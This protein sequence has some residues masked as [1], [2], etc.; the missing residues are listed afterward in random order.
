MTATRQSLRRAARPRDPRLWA[1]L[2][3]LAVAGGWL[4]ERIG[5]PAGYLFAAM[6][7]GLCFALL[8]PGR[9]HLSDGAFKLG[10]AV[11]GVTIGTFLQGSTLGGLGWRWGPVLA[12]SAATLAVTLAAGLWLARSGPVDP[13]TASLGMV[14]GGASGIVAMAEEL[15]G[16]ERLVAFM[17]Y[18]RVLIVT[19]LTTLMIPIVFGVHAADVAGGGEG[20]GPLGTLSGWALTLGA[21]TLGVLVGPRLRLPAP[22]LLGPLLLTAALSLSGL[23]PADA[24]VP[25]L[26][27]DV[28]FALIGAR[29]GLGFEP[30]TL[31]RIAG[32]ALPVTAA[33]A[34]LLIACVG[35]AWVLEVTTGVSFLDGYLATTPGGLYA[36]LPIAYGSGADTTFVLAV[37]GLR[38]LVMVIAAPLVVRRL[39]RMPAPGAAAG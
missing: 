9:L 12:V 20:A 8:L 24:E 28:G 11:I 23:L 32:L 33:M 34:G 2:A 3:A 7:F 17:Q 21:G 27:R 26:L 16:D 4:A 6:L 35:L 38:L 15:G 37:Q 14:A 39:V 1:L 31:R 22:A 29:I 25:A 30:E 5:L 19:A 10:Q 13:A 36:V 18:L